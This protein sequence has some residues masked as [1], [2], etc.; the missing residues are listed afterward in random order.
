MNLTINL[1]YRG[2]FRQGG[3][4]QRQSIGGQSSLILSGT[5]ISMRLGWRS[6]KPK[7]WRSCLMCSSPAD[8]LNII[9]LNLRR[10]SETFIVAGV[11]MNLNNFVE[12]PVIE[13]LPFRRGRA[14]F[15]LPLLAYPERGDLRLVQEVDEYSN[16]ISGYKVLEDFTS[17]DAMPI[18]G[19]LVVVGGEPVHVFITESGIPHAGK[20][21]EISSV[22][23]EF[24][25]RCPKEHA[26]ILQIRELIGAQPGKENGA[27]CDAREYCS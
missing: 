27:A 2:P 17:A 8:I 26:V 7:V 22:L 25:I 19:P 14:C 13:F 4:S 15:A 3:S 21:N 16:L 18:N 23:N 5:T 1:F 11:L 6:S 9:M 20:L 10:Q 24:A 12:L